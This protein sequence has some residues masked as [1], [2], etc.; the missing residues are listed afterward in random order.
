MGFAEK[1]GVR[2]VFLAAVA[3][4]FRVPEAKVIDAEDAPEATLL[5]I[6]LNGG[7]AIVEFVAALVPDSR[8][9]GFGCLVVEAAVLRGV[10]IGF[11][12]RIIDR[13]LAT[14]DESA[15]NGPFRAIAV[16]TRAVGHYP[17]LVGTQW[18]S[19]S[20]RPLFE[21]V[22]AN[23]ERGGSIVWSESKCLR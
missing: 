2:A 17:R 7:F 5:D 4:V 14:I 21:E 15:K 9:E 1:R 10:E 23:Y 13:E 6:L 16:R 11:L 22:I 18:M 20:L 3:S 19:D 12:E 8:S